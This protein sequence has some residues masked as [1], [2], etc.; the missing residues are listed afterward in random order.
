[1]RSGDYGFLGGE[2]HAAASLCIKCGLER[3]ILCMKII[4]FL[5]PSP[6]HI[7]YLLKSIHDNDEEIISWFLRVS[8]VKFVLNAS[9]S[10]FLVAHS[11]NFNQGAVRRGFSVL[12]ALMRATRNFGFDI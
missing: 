7:G 4:S 5:F 11:K 3:R 12:L 2:F 9:Y 6:N 8:R 10:N 1:M